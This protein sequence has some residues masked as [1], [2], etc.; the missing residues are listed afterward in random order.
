MI[1]DKATDAHILRFLLHL[2]ILAEQPE[3]TMADKVIVDFG[4]GDVEVGHGLR[5]SFVLGRLSIL[6]RIL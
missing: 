4:A 6:E 5:S 3:F 1:V 2:D